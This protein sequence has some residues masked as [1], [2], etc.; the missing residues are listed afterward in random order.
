M[1][2][3]VPF[4]LTHNNAAL[5]RMAC[6]LLALVSQ[7]CFIV[8]G[9]GGEPLEAAT[10]LTLWKHCFNVLFGLSGFFVLASWDKKP[11]ALR[12]ATAR[13]LRIM[14]A[15]AVAALITV[16]GGALLTTL[17][18]GQYLSPG[19]LLTYLFKAVV[20]LDGKVTLPG[21]FGP[22]SDINLVLVPL[23]MLKYLVVCYA[24]VLA[25]GC[26]RLT[27]ATWPYLLGLGLFALISLAQGFQPDMI[28]PDS[29]PAHG[30]RFCSCFFIGMSCW[31]FRHLLP[32]QIGI[33]AAACALLALALM[34]G[35]LSRALFYVIEIYV[36]LW[37]SFRLPVLDHPIHK[38]N[39]DF[40][41]G[42]CL[43][44][45]FISQSLR[46]IWPMVDVVP[47]MIAT[48]SLA[49]AAAV[50]SW[51]FIEQPARSALPAVLARIRV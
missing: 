11:E 48:L 47:L 24:A 35:G 2:N 4:S 40:T 10:G 30:L 29:V 50:L 6:M 7:I 42:M 8:G 41:L 5:V 33:F 32:L 46:V 1:K 3:P 14:P 44:G 17:P 16:I 19:P 31:R 20:L 9:E 36:A 51:L 26:L 12:F 21:V 15:L 13:F 22:P 37:L 49:P 45:W 25:M 34:F 23:W 39:Q 18:L 27:R 43:Y 28:P 38:P